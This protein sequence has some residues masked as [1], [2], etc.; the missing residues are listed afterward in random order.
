MQRLISNKKAIKIFEG[1]ENFAYRT[2]THI[3]VI[4]EGFVD[5]LIGKKVPEQKISLIPNW[6][7]T[8]FIRPLPK[9][10][11]FPGRTWAAK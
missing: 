6:V 4:A 9:K 3:S 2:S 7:N 11:W 5:N 1:L 10:K 8:N